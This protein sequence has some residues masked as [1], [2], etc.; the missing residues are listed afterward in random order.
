MILNILTSPQDLNVIQG[1]HDGAFVLLSW[2]VALAASY[3]G[4]DIIKLVRNRSQPAWRH[5][6]L[7]AG[8]SAMGLGVWSMH[9]IGMH[10]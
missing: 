6:W 1:E 3:A 5:A 10:A 4:L 7:W 2:L 8:A 9:F